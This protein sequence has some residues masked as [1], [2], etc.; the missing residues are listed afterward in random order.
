[1]VIAAPTGVGKTL[2]M[3]VAS[4]DTDT[5]GLIILPLLSLE[6]QMERDLLRLGI[7]FI[8]LTACST[9]DLD[10]RLKARPQIVLTSVEALADKAKREVLRKSRLVIG[11][12]AWDEAMVNIQPGKI[13]TECFPLQVMHST[14]GWG[15]FRADYGDEMFRYLASTYPRTPGSL[16]RPHWMTA[17]SPALPRV[18]GSTGFPAS[19]Y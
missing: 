16:P 14:E 6:Q 13:A 4:L 10:Q 11:H 7:S 2:P 1:M 15:G 8:N 12:I 17:A 18:W 5:L 3:I 19:L 9:S